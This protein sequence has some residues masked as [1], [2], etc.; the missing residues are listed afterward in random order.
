MARRW[1]LPAVASAAVGCTLVLTAAPVA[2]ANSTVQINGGNVPTTAAGHPTHQCSPNQ[3]GGP[4]AGSDV[5]VFVLPGDYATSGDFV[6]VTAQFSTDAD[7][8]AD[9]TKVITT[10]G[11]G[12]LNG[13]PAVSKAWIALPL[14]WK[15]IT[16]SA[17][18]TGEAA[19][20]NLSHT[21]PAG[22]STTPPVTTP[23]VT[24]PPVTT[25]GTTTT[26]TPTGTPTDPGSSTS[27]DPDLPQTGASLSGL[28]AAGAALVI[29]GAALLFLRQR[30][31][32][33][34]TDPV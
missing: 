6:S 34:E 25:P 9:V 12:F 16:A 19:F 20:F 31:D 8:V 23:P 26:P 28:I 17:V 30:R 22:T 15:L 29:A 11:G 2:W 3:G 13:G 27:H 18:I 21:C 32:R 7:D 33:Q 4:Y 10:D 14:G 24:T 5:W 1:L